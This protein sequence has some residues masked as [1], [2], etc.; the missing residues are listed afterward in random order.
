MRALVVYES[1]YGNTRAVAEAIAA[2][3]APGY[4]ATTAP[5]GGLAAAPLADVDLL[6]VGGPTHA[7]GLS[8]PTTRQNAVAAAQKPGSGLTVEPGAT[9]VGLREWLGSLTRAGNTVA[10]AFDTRI[11][12]P[13]LITGRASRAIS[14][15]L[16][17]RGYPVIAKPQS[18]LVQKNALVPGETDRARDWGSQLATATQPA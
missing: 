18:F 14:R 3:L 7:W 1:M 6:V 11:E 16:M 9:G 12:A 13:A 10:A 5:V 4:E 15:A 17:Q 2:G 8:R